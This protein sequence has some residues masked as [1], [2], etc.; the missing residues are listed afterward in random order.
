M[1][2]GSQVAHVFVRRGISGILRSHVPDISVFDAACFIAVP[3]M[4]EIKKK[5]FQQSNLCV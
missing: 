1:F 3:T 2:R 5:K 4:L